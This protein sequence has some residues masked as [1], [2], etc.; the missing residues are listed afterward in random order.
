MKTYYKL[1]PHNDWMDLDDFYKEAAEQG[2]VNNSNRK[3]M[4]D[5]FKNEEKSQVF[6]LF[7]EDK[8]MGATAVHTFPEMGENSYRILTR[9]CV[10]G[11]MLHNAGSMGRMKR[12][13]DLTSRFY[14]PKMIQWCGMDSNMYCTTNDLEGGSQRAVH[15]IWLPIMSKQGLFTKIKEIDYRGVT[16]TVWKLNPKEFLAHLENNPWEDH[17]LL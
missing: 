15:R 7:K 9:T 6:I 1:L 13:E 5:A 14:V 2:Y 17:V 10:V 3:I 16:Q 11:G 4:I 12:C 8:A